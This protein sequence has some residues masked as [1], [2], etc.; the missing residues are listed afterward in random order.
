MKQFRH[1]LHGPKFR[2][3]TDHAPLPS[4]LQ[5]KE[6]EGQL[7]RWIEFMS[8]FS[9]EIE[10]RAGQRHIRMPTHC[11]EGL[12]TVAANGARSG[13]GLS[14]WL[15]LPFKLMFHLLCVASL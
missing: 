4:V 12:V 2:I 14:K 9:Y 10:Y 5:V 6:P 1:Y 7:A 3:R 11:R 15:V 13:R 8:S